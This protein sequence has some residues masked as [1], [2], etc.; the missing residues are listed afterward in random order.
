MFFSQFLHWM[1]YKKG[2]VTTKFQKSIFLL[3]TIDVT[4]FYNT[5]LNVKRS[6][7]TTAA[8]FIW[9][10]QPQHLAIYS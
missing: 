2:K 7:Y 1:N 3:F 6:L 5:I 4:H 9:Q 8:V 10:P